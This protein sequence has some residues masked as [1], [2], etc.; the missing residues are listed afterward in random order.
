MWSWEEGFNEVKVFLVMDNNRKSLIS[1]GNFSARPLTT[2]AP[3]CRRERDVSLL[4]SI[5]REMRLERLVH[6]GCNDIIF[7][8]REREKDGVGK[9][10]IGER[11]WDRS[12]SWDMINSIMFTRPESHLATVCVHNYSIPRKIHLFCRIFFSLDKGSNA[13]VLKRTFANLEKFYQAS[14]LKI[15]AKFPKPTTKPG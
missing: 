8:E 1:S 5:S 6:V 11:G 4:L 9:I 15:Y 12:C 14:Y 7:F 2:K 10:N 13:Q 3:L